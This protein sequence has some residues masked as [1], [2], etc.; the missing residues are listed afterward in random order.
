MLSSSLASNYQL[1]LPQTYTPV[2]NQLKLVGGPYNY[3][4]SQS[5][6]YSHSSHIQLT[7]L[8]NCNRWNMLTIAGYEIW[9]KTGPFNT[10][11]HKM[12]NVPYFSED[13]QSLT[14][15]PFLCRAACR[16]WNKNIYQCPNRSNR[17]LWWRYQHTSEAHSWNICWQNIVPQ[18]TSPS[19]HHS[20]LQIQGAPTPTAPPL[21]SLQ[22][23]QDSW[24]E[25]SDPG[26]PS[27]VAPEKCP[28]GPSDVH[29]WSRRN[30]SPHGL[31]QHL[32][33]PLTAPL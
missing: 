30:S 8:I 28:L 1:P 31:H 22:I 2:V 9:L 5:W 14:S 3:T 11:T 15:F 7:H 20:L 18:Q 23:T 32:W 27:S 24:A 6:F 16:P 29:Q 17:W 25:A 26:L 4:I 12:E 13:V 21:Y 19:A 33:I 10:F